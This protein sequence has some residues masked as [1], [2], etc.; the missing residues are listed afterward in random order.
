MMFL[1]I[2]IIGTALRLFMIG[3][4]GFVADVCFWKSWGLAALD[5]GVVWTTFHTNINYPPGFIYVLWL[6]AKIYSFFADPHHYD[7]Y[8]RENNFAFL[9]ASKSIAIISDILITLIIY[10]FFSRKKTLEKLGSII[11]SHTPMINSKNGI[12]AR[13]VNFIHD[14]LGLVLASVFFLNP[15][16][17]L[18]SAIWG[19]VESFGLLF[20]I[21][22]I[23]LIFYKR[24]VL[25]TVFFTAGTLMKLQNIIYIPIYFV[26]LLRY[27]DFRTIVR[28]FISAGVTFLVINFPFVRSNSLNQVLYLMTVN[29][30]YFPWLSLNAHNLWWIVAGGKG[31]QITDKITVFG[32]LNA[33]KVGLI[34]F[35][36]FYLLPT[37]LTFLRPTARN[38]LLSLNIGIFAFFL[39]TTQSHERYSYPLLVLLLFF[40]P[41][42]KTKLN[43]RENSNKSFFWDV[44]FWGLYGFLTL[45]IFINVYMGL[46]LN[47]PDNGFYPLTKMMTPT[48]G[49]LN[50]YLL[51]ILFFFML[52]FIYRELHNGFFLLS[53]AVATALLLSANSSYLIGGK[54]SLTKYTPIIAA[55]DY[56]GVQINR[57]VNSFGGWKTWSRLN[58][59][60]FYYPKG[61]G[62]HA[63]SRLVFDIKGMYRKFKTDYGIDAE[64]PTPASVIFKIS[65]DGKLLFESE[66]MGRFDLPKH[67]EVDITGVKQLELVANDAG[68]GINSDHADWLNPVLLK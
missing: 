43:F 21:I 7:S 54:V 20:T 52:A 62:V 55:Q 45:T 14:N 56:A 66:K 27:F 1:L 6:M 37:L 32:I 60:Y 23:I 22:A 8:W 41:F 49:I 68:D 26:F 36:S 16:V 59:D 11:V 57:S 30:D 58:I 65:G 33:K 53:P 28:C 19:Q 18:D 9:F 2:L 47:Y 35:S 67:V 46:I 63:N 25:A 50:S 61:F 44:F 38:F 5:H 34:L 39:W 29:S 4:P 51:I 17:M 15:V 3:N 10:W 12:L 31:M 40:Y 42:M 48:V 13:T 64:S 24:P